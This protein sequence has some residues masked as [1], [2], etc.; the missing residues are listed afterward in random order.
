MNLTLTLDP[1]ILS[2]ALGEVE[3]G[4]ISGRGLK[5]GCAGWTR[6]YADGRRGED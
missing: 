6:R 2:L 3:S 5:G 4:V 1:L